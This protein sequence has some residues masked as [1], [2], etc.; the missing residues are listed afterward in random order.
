MDA[1]LVVGRVSECEMGWVTPQYGRGRVDAA[2]RTLALPQASSTYDEALDIINNWRSSHGFPLNTIQI[3]LRK[4]ARRVSADALVAQRIKRLSSIRLKLVDNPHMALSQMQDIGGCR[5]VVPNIGKV[6]ELVRLHES[7]SHKHKQARFDDY[8]NKPKA[9]GYRGVHIIYKYFSDRTDTWNDLRIEVQLR[10][11]LQH[12][13]ATAVETVGTFVRQAL[14]SSHGEEDW[15]RFFA[16]MGAAIARMENSPLPPESP[17]RKMSLVSELKR[18]ASRLDVETRLT[19]YQAALHTLEDPS[20][21]ARNTKY[22]LL[23]LDLER[24]VVEVSGFTERR[25]WEA[26]QRYLD[27][28]KRIAD[29]PDAEAVLVSVDS[30]QLLRRAYPNYFLDTRRFLQAYRRAVS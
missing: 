29:R 30:L 5:A 14:K 24:N 19:A 20:A 27:T 25:L 23:A 1:A 8:I 13:W 22:L 7:A 2:G 12:A 21:K 17:S 3:G 11:Q 9:S 4:R 6:W 10:S 26:S 16:L 28:E 15:L 18:Y